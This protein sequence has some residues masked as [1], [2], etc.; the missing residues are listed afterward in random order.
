M[1][2]FP[3]SRRN[4]RDI[5]GFF[6]GSPLFSGAGLV[7]IFA[8]RLSA[9]GELPAELIGAPSEAINIFDFRAVAKVALIGSLLFVIDGAFQGSILAQEEETT[10]FVPVVG[11]LQRP[12]FRLRD[13]EGGSHSVSEWDGRVVLIDFWASW[14][15]PCRKEMP[16]FNELRAK[17]LGQGFEVIG[18]AA[19]KVENIE[20]FLSEIKVD[21]PI[22]FGDVF[23]VM[24]IAAD[25][26][27]SYGGLPFNA[28]I[29]REGNIRYVQKPGEVTFEEA[30]EILKRLL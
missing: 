23:E 19:D 30:E 28:F 10:R 24:G 27:N 7:S 2:G 26:G 4:R 17:Y 16:A 9:S 6:K 29:D 12:S 14:C 20:R 11:E 15:I 13:L 22:L 21:F 1:T 25:Y 3:I 8:Q 5:L 18:I